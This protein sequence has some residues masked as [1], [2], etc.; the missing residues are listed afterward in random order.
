MGRG[1]RYGRPRKRS[2]SYSSPQEFDLATRQGDEAA[3]LALLERCTAESTFGAADFLDLA[4]LC[5]Q[6]QG[7]GSR[8]AERAA[9][10]AALQALL[11]EASP[12]YTAV[13]QVRWPLHAQNAMPPVHRPDMRPPLLHPSL[14]MRNWQLQDSSCARCGC[15]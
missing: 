2:L 4:G 11:A 9:L 15:E 14:P 13:A 8:A 10:R 3:Q 6:Q 1:L 12:D 7:G 5:Q